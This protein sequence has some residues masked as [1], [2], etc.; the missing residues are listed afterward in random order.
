[1]KTIICVHTGGIGAVYYDRNTCMLRRQIDNQSKGLKRLVV[2][3]I[4]LQ[5]PPA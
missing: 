3:P 4:Q 1:M 2:R 5:E